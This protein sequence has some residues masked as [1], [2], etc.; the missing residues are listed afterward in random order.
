MFKKNSKLILG[1][2]FAVAL[3]ACIFIFK[4]EISKLKNFGYLGL[5]L[6]NVLGS[7]TVFLPT[8]L[9]L[10]AFAAGAVLNPFVVTIIASLGSSIGE[11]TGYYIGLGGGEIAEHDKRA[12]KIEGWMQ[13]YGGWTL[14]FLAAIPN[15]VFDVAGF[16]AGATK[17][18]VSKYLFFVWMGKIVKFGV[19][20]Y[21]G[22]GSSYVFAK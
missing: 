9:F 14:F 20:T 13:K 5:F 19:I 4:D 15:P 12:K 6:L 22:A 17:V 1:I 11:L 7:A 18:T 16:V 8:P 2:L 3:S 21:L 10:T